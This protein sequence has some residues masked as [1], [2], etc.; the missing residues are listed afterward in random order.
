[1][2]DFMGA[3]QTYDNLIIE[4]REIEIMS[5]ISSLLSWDQEVIMPENGRA[6]RA[7]QLAWISKES[8]EKITNSK[9]GEMLDELEADDNFNETQTANIRLIREQYDKATKK[10]SWF[11]EEFARHSSKSLHS[12]QEARANDDF[13]IFRDDLAKMIELNR[14][15][16]DFLG[17]ENN[18]YDALLDIYETGLTVE[19]VDPLFEGLRESL[20]P[21]VKSVAEKAEKVSDK[22]ID[23]NSFPIKSQ[24][25]ISQYVAKALGFN[26]SAGRRDMSTHPFCGGTGPDDVRWTTRYDENEPFGSLYGSMH[27]VGHAL[28]EQGRPRNLDLQP[29]G[30]AV[31]LGIHESQ[32]RLWENQI[33]RSLEFCEWVLPLWKKEFPHMSGITTEQFWRAVNRT[34]P[35]LIRVE[36]DEATYNLHIMIRYEIEKKLINGDLEVDDLP[37]AWNDAYEAYLGIRSPNNTLG[38]LQ[39]VH[40]SMGAIGYFPTYTLGNLYAAQLLETARNEL[41]NLEDQVRQG[42]FSHLLDWMRKHI[43]AKG[44]I[45]K[46]EDLILEVTGKLPSPEPFVSYLRSKLETLYGI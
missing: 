33:G 20:I 26:F 31:S 34:E 42:E 23:E 9:I 10:P 22:W 8:H 32:S 2:E 12:W 45:L 24:E 16:A 15:L 13:S 30:H 4:I 37:D 17:W 35:S 3:E 27:E 41:S 25:N 43:H 39:D 36:A 18:R 44:S 1:M 40:W 29:A 46:P 6:L 28:Y 21:L 11:V 19:Q 14:Q 7:E 5:Q 38:V